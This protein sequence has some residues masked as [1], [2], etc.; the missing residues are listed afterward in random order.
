M[1]TTP[2]LAAPALALAVL[3]G[4]GGTAAQLHA[5]DPGD[6]VGVA[7]AVQP[8]TT[9]QR[10]G[11]AAER[12]DIG[13]AIVF[14][15]VIATDP[16]G[17]AQ[18]SFLDRSSLTV[19]PASRLT[20]DRFVYQP[21][22][23]AGGLSL[24]AS[25]GVFRYVGGA[26]S[27]QGAVSVTTPVATLGIRGAI[28]LITVE[29]DGTTIATMLFG[30]RLTARVPGG[31]SVVATPGQTVVIRPGETAPRPP[32]PADDDR[33]RTTL[34]AL[35]GST[36][37]RAGTQRP[38]DLLTCEDPATDP[39]GVGTARAPSDLLPTVAGLC[40]DGV[41]ATAGPAIPN[42]PDLPSTGQTTVTTTTIP[43]TPTVPTTPTTPGTTAGTPGTTGGTTAPTYTF[44][45]GTYTPGT[46]P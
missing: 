2:S 16:G 1:R 22:E 11:G 5:A 25:T 17:R 13:S 4:V 27:K 43:T 15:Q 34:R 18:I 35:D 6:R 33:I 30:E 31:G 23:G 37:I 10:P 26:L 41:P 21:A 46:S 9:G 3:I 44:G 28:V 42:L 45:S 14:H 39:N 20:I 8:A 12:I 36:I 24:S 32:R 40:N 19:G 7:G 29:A 38:E